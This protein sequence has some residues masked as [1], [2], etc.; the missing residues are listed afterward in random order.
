MSSGFEG[1]YRNSG[2]MRNQGF[3]ATITGRLMEKKDF[4]WDLTVM[5]STMK[6]KVLK[7]TDDGKDILSGNQIIREGEAIYSAFVSHKMNSVFVQSCITICQKEGSSSDS[8][9]ATDVTRC[10]PTFSKSDPP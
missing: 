1:Y 5:A 6:N 8:S 9:K 7:L 4:S 2:S 10:G 3:E